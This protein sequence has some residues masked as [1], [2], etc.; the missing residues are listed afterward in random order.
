MSEHHP[1]QQRSS[2]QRSRARHRARRRGAAAP[3][4]GGLLAAALLTGTAAAPAAAAP[5]I[6]YETL[7]PRCSPALPVPHPGCAE[8]RTYRG[9]PLPSGTPGSFGQ[10]A[11]PDRFA[12]AAAVA[13]EGF[14]EADVAVL[15]SGEDAHLVDALSAAPL[16]R[17]LAAPLLLATRDAVPAAT[18]AY[19][20]ERGVRSV[21]LVGGADALGELTAKRL[22]ALGVEHVARVAGADRY[23]TSRALAELMPRAEHAWAA[24]GEQAH[25]VDALAAA[26]PAAGLG[27]P[28]VVLPDDPAVA[29]QAAR[30]LSAL[31]VRET[32]VAGGDEGVAD[33]AALRMPGAERVFAADRYGTAGALASAGVGR[34]LPAGQFTV[35]PGAERHLVD[36]LAAGTL[37]RAVVLGEDLGAARREVA[38]WFGSAPVVRMTTVGAVRLQDALP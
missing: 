19:L 4:T 23:A 2:R 28:L 14:P 27:Q 12:T 13:R 17:S 34:G 24:S 9:A 38:V 26:G 25:L 1:S 8:G 31:G 32:T 5:E 21:L 10:L 11:G 20:G 37:G 36:G 16:A 18:S 15:V 6:G 22:R 33:E 3:L 30:T 35:A 7:T 29:E